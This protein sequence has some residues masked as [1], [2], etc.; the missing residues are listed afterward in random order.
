MEETKEETNQ[1][2]RFER[3]R[4]LF[5]LSLER[6]TPQ[7]LFADCRGDREEQQNDQ[8]VQRFDREEVAESIFDALRKRQDMILH[9][10]VRF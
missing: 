9:Q 1:E 8:R 3:P 5:E 2:N 6:S 4:A 7:G 10:H